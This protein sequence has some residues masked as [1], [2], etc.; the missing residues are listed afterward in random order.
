MMTSNLNP[1][2][3]AVLERY[4]SSMFH[5]ETELLLS[6][7]LGKDRCIFLPVDVNWSGSCMF[8]VLIIHDGSNL[9][10]E[11]EASLA[12]GPEMLRCAQH[13]RTGFA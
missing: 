10:G 8:H 5:F 7:L 4:V 9:G 13:D 12:L 11:R 3:E 1:A 6:R 2:S